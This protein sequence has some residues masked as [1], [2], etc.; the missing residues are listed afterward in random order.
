M[1]YLCTLCD[2]PINGTHHYTLPVTY[3]LHDKPVQSAGHYLLHAFDN[4]YTYKMTVA[5]P[6][7]HFGLD[8]I[9]NLKQARDWDLF[10]P[11]EKNGYR[12]Y[13]FYDCEHIR[14]GHFQIGEIYKAGTSEVDYQ[15]ILFSPGLYEGYE[16]DNSLVPVV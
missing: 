13:P 7:V 14:Y 4:A 15:T 6:E 5:P 8:D 3:T 12:Y 16:L 10:I 9:K 1:V 2:K 11:Y